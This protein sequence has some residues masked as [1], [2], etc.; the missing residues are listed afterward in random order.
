[1]E[2]RLMLKRCWSTPHSWSAHTFSTW[3]LMPSG[4]AALPWFNLS[5]SLHL[6]GCN[7]NSCM[8]GGRCGRVCRGCLQGCEWWGVNVQGLQQ[9]SVRGWGCEGGL[10]PLLTAST[11]GEWG[12][13]RGI[14]SWGLNEWA[15]LW[16]S[17]GADRGGRAWIKSV[18]KLVQLICPLWSAKRGQGNRAVCR[19]CIQQ[20]G[21]IKITCDCDERSW[22][23][24][25]QCH[26]YWVNYVTCCFQIPQ[27][28]DVNSDDNG[29]SRFRWQKVR[30]KSNDNQFDIPTAHTLFNID[31]SWIAPS[32]VVSLSQWCLYR[33]K[34]SEIWELPEL[35]QVSVKYMIEM[36]CLNLLFFNFCLLLA[37]HLHLVLLR[38]T[39][40][41]GFP[42]TARVDCSRVLSRLYV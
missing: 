15:A 33:H 42:M 22:I 26:S 12:L 30:V 24:C 16:G 20:I 17:V 40:I 11:K 2:L 9:V 21:M 37:L 8:G 31:V 7:V 35:I 18:E 5:S 39:G 6:A 23:F 19:I 25:G 10:G 27:Q 1:M 13:E 41:E 3:G 28:W 14:E 4:P 38:S 29:A 34:P 32:G 36:L